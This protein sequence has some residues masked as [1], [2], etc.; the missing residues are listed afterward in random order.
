MK[1]ITDLRKVFSQAEKR[2]EAGLYIRVIIRGLGKFM[3][4]RWFPIILWE[5]GRA[6]NMRI[7]RENRRAVFRLAYFGFSEKRGELHEN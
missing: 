1:K 2:P 7:L 4:R 6:L 5:L 3:E